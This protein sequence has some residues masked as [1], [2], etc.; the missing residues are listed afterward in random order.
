MGDGYGY[1][2]LTK[3]LIK[4][5]LIYSSSRHCERSAAI[6]HFVPKRGSGFPHPATQ[7]LPLKALLAMTI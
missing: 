6:Q 7:C 2:V 3:K 5:T 4:V 1:N